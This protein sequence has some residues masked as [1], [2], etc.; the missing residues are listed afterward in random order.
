MKKL[1][2]EEER[3]QL[4]EINK[5][6]MLERI[7]KEAN[8]FTTKSLVEEVFLGKETLSIGKYI[9]IFYKIHPEER[10]IEM[11]ESYIFNGVE[12]PEKNVDKEDEISFI[13]GFDQKDLCKTLIRRWSETSKDHHE[14]K[15]IFP[16]GDFTAYGI[17]NNTIK[18]YQFKQLLL[19]MG[20]DVPPFFD[21]D[22]PKIPHRKSTS[23][24]RISISLAELKE[25]FPNQG[26]SSKQMVRLYVK[27]AAKLIIRHKLML[28]SKRKI[29]TQEIYKDPLMK[30]T[31]E[32][33]KTEQ[34]RLSFSGD[35][36]EDTI[37][38]WIKEVLN[39]LA[40]KNI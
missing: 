28:D 30:K 19:D 14:F 31:L 40:T 15:T 22:I 26:M 2:T 16:D 4:S 3:D 11:V 18:R 8:K 32:I 35:K 39:A 33:L 36:E 24:S 27:S 20:V 12:Y 34:D 1:L 13:Q 38:K 5:R 9:L 7:K 6:H 23:T 37:L 29:Q 17:T 25:G 21:V 10:H